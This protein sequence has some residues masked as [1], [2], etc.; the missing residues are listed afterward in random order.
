MT[1]SYTKQ[2]EIEKTQ[3]LQE[4]L[5]SA[6]QQEKD[7]LM[8]PHPDK[9]S[10]LQITLSKNLIKLDYTLHKHVMQKETSTKYLRV[11]IQT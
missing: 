3:N 4:F 6:T 8:S 10:V 1:V 2:Y 11:T 7:W 9:C 5:T